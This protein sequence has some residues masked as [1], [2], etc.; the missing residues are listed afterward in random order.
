MHVNGYPQKKASEMTGEALVSLT[1]SGLRNHTGAGGVCSRTTL[2]RVDMLR[3]HTGAARHARWS[4]G[5]VHIVVSP[6]E[7]AMADLTLSRALWMSVTRPPS[8]HLFPQMV[9]AATT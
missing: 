8:N 7:S 5:M 1:L 2:V 4:Q 6:L 3:I 9:S